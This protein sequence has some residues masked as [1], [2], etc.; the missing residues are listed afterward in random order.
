MN[1]SELEQKA[2]WVRRQVLEMA[3]RAG[4]GRVAS[5]LSCADIL[6]ALFHGGALHF[7]P[8]NPRWEG[9][10]RFVL[11]KGQGALA[12]YPVLADLGFFSLSELDRYCQ[13]GAML[14]PYGG[15]NLPGV[16][17]I[18]GSLG[19]GLGVACGLAL[20]ARMDGKPHS[21]VVLV[22]DGECYEGSTWEAAMFAAHHRLSN[23]VAIIDRNWMCVTD[24]TE[25]CLRLESL[26]DKWR[27]FGWET[28]IVPGH[29]L[30]ALLSQ[31]HRFH[32][33]STAG[34]L[35]PPLVV[36]AETVKGKGIS[37]L[38]NNILGHVTIPRGEELE[39]ARRELV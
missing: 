36:I 15:E 3:V 29:D 25:H 34:N 35:L 20:A 18:W 26:A 22:S 21:V 6:V 33:R 17:G 31:F 9:R 28:V 12:L 1:I 24:Y 23:L 14:G 4:E 38:E 37:S 11:S 32:T 10:D 13:P 16:D 5:S 8:N 30:G 39:R 19:H 27:A 2:Q 7:D